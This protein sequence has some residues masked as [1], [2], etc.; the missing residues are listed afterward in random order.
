MK[1][2]ILLLNFGEPEQPVI[3]EVVP[4]LERI[5]LLN[6][7]LEGHGADAAR[8]R[9]QQL[10]TARAPGLID[11][12]EEIGGSPLH[13][14]AREQAERLQDE[15]R[16]RGH[17]ALV[18]VGMQFTEPSIA[19]A[20]ASAREAG[21]E[22]VVGLPL[23]PLC[24]PST[25]MAALETFRAE[26]ARQGWDVEVSEISG[27]HRHPDYIEFRAKAIRE[28]LDE[29]DLELDATVKLVFSAHG[30]P[31]KYLDEGS[32][33]DLYVKE[34]CASVASK[35]EVT[36]YVIGYQNHTNRPGVKWTQ[37]DVDRVIEDIDAECVVVD[38]VSF[39]HE[40]SE[41]L[42]ELDRE[43]RSDAEARGLRFFRVPIEHAAP[44]F[45]SVLADLAE[46]LVLPDAVDRAGTQL[47]PCLCR[48][49]SATYCLNGDGVTG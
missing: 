19:E 9:A 13:A 36:D 21:V 49:T 30:T 44:V 5:F 25:T 18:L 14:Q 47:K 37:P 24:G 45:I 29:H 12:Y 40:Q 17:D 42:A 35:L 48:A 27:W 8:E 10:A 15:L 39:M 23:Y 11:E 1:L 33:Y 46:D 22:H 32:R 34:F 3:A 2:G 4:F 31:I 41:T 16:R 6:A 26:I 20:V 28:L 38:P 43:L 7:D